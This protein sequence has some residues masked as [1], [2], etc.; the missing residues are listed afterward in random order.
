[1]LLWVCLFLPSF[2]LRLLI[3]DEYGLDIHVL[4]TCTRNTTDAEASSP[5]LVS[6]SLDHFLFTH[7]GPLG[8]CLHQWSVIH[9]TS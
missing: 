8:L 4:C 3:A 9:T 1:M 6:H 2:S 7:F 5:Y